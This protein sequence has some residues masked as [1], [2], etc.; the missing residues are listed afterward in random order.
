MFLSGLWGQLIG[1]ALVALFITAL[2]IAICEAI[3]KE[4]KNEKDL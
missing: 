4:D 1:G 2:I 3:F